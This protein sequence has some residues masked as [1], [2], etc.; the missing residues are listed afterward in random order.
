M[1]KNIV[2]IV[3]AALIVVVIAVVA[4]FAGMKISINK[5]AKAVKAEFEEMFNTLKTGQSK[6]AEQLIGAFAENEVGAKFFSSLSYEILDIDAGTKEATV[7]LTVTN[8]DMKTV[9][10]NYISEAFSL[11]FSNAFSSEL[12]EEELD[13]K[14]NTLLEE[15]LDSTDVEMITTEVTVHLTKVD[16]EWQLDEAD[17]EKLTDAILPGLKEAVSGLIVDEGTTTETP[18][19]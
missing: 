3:V 6:D 16:G 9:I 19:E 17:Q 7:T 14:L 12:T 1:K 13:A 11:A 8:K 15:K 4:V 5:Q 10:A 18:V 2:K